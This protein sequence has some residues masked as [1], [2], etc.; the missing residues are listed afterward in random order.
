M[1]IFAALPERLSSPSVTTSSQTILVALLS[2][3]LNVSE[4]NIPS[5][6]LCAGKKGFLAFQRM[7]QLYTEM[8]EE[9]YQNQETEITIL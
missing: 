7:D 1:K 4:S 6:G 8:Q 3:E 9:A 5:C 2:F